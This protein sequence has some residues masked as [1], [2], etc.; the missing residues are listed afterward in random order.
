MPVYTKQDLIDFSPTCDNFVGVD[1]DGCVFDTME[2]KQKQFFHGRIVSHWHL[3][4][5]EPQVRAAAEFVNLRS[6]WRG[7]NRFPAL[8]R[9][10]R[11]LQDWPDAADHAEL[12]DCTALEAYVNS[13]LPLGNPSLKEEVART[14][15]AD[16]QRVLDWSLDVSSAIANDMQPIPPFDGAVAALGV[17]QHKSDVI[18]VSQTPEEDLIREWEHH[19]IAQFVQLI[20][21]Q[22]LGKKS[23]HLTMAA[24]GKYADN[25]VLMIGDSLND[26]KAAQEAGALFYPTLPGKESESW[27]RFVEDAYPKFLA[28]E[29]A[30]AYQDELIATFDAMLPETPPWQT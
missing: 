24:G 23:E 12:P 22:E 28:H 29:F 17:M 13:G 21:G 16:L 18:V 10:F 20:A 7:S 2:V 27:E 8:L 19:N 15:D 14:D 6:K 30:G 4:A 25:C 26:M 3:E 5:I 1:S 11:L 9:V